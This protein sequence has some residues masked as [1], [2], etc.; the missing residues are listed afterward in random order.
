LNKI[1][2]AAKGAPIAADE[3]SLALRRYPSIGFSNMWNIAA[4]LWINPGLRQA[5]SIRRQPNGPLLSYSQG[6]CETILRAR[7]TAKADNPI[8]T[9]AELSIK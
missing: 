3:T 7:V 2:M 6:Y 1:V 5:S 9:K 4:I 8:A